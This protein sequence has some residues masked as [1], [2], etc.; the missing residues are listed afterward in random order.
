MAGIE[1]ASLYADPADYR[2]LLEGFGL[3]MLRKSFVCPVNILFS[4]ALGLLS[5]CTPRGS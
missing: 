2:Q 1:Y 3:G 5:E 4:I